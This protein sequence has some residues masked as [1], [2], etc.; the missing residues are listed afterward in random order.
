[1]TGELL[2]SRAPT[3]ANPFGRGLAQVAGYLAAGCAVIVGAVLALIF[4]A[5]LVVIAV[6]ASVLIA[7]AGLAL[8]ARRTAAV[9]ARGGPQYLEAR[10]VGHSWVAYGWDRR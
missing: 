2:E 5:S 8:R 10:K 9:R 6:V 4:A 7:F 1:M 3:F